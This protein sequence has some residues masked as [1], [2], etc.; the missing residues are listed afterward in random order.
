[1]SR[2]RV[3][4]IVMA[5]GFAVLPG[6]AAEISVSLVNKTV[7]TLCAEKDNV[8]LE[9]VSRTARSLRVDA[10]HPNYIGGLQID[11]SAP[12]WHNCTGFPSDPAYAYTPRRVTLYETAHWQIIGYTFAKFWRP[13]SPPITVG[14]EVF[15]DIHLIQVWTRVDERAEEVLVLYPGDGYWRAR[16]LPPKHL[17]WSAYG[18]SFLVGPVEM[19]GRPIVDIKA[20]SIDPKDLTFSMDF[21]RG[22]KGALHL[23]YLDRDVISLDVSLEKPVGGEGVFAALRSMYVSDINNDMA[24]IGWREPGAESWREGSV[25]EIKRIEAAEIWAGRTVHSRHNTS[26]PDMIFG[27]FRDDGRIEGSGLADP[28]AKPQN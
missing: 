4:F 1:M 5:L 14:K 17:G 3:F 11:R 28:S 6:K 13:N 20:L 25:A 2:A 27:A 18:S 7:P 22:G 8:T 15:N 12:D 16:P 26:A 10:R 9:L 19:Q 23:S 24:R 21:A